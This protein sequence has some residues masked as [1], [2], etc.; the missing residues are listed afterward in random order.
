MVPRRFAVGRYTQAASVR[1]VKTLLGYFVA[2][3]AKASPVDMS[4]KAMIR[5]RRHNFSAWTR[6]SSAPPGGNASSALDAI[7]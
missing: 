5:S 2:G 3:P 4:D 1:Q 7:H 6:S